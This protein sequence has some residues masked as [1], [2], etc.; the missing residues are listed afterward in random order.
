MDG[1]LIGFVYQGAIKKMIR[2]LKYYH[3]AQRA[4][5]IAQRLQRLVMDH[6]E[7]SPHPNCVIGYVPS[8]RY[9]RYRVKG[10]NQSLLLA[11]QLSARTGLPV[12]HVATKTRHTQSQVSLSRQSRWNNLRDV[13]ALQESG[14]DDGIARRVY[15]VDDLTTTGATF[16]Y[17]AQTIKKTHPDREVRGCAVARSGG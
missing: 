4:D 11:Q 15:I 6:L 7:Q 1:C 16:H 17:L 5:T 10:Y 8:H 3:R 2:R 14:I 12:V 9:R 13:F